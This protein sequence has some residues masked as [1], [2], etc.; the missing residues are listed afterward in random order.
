[1]NGNGGF[2]SRKRHLTGGLWSVND[3]RPASVF[4]PTTEA[5]ADANTFVCEFVG[6]ANANETGVGL[7]LTGA[8][9]VLT[10]VGSVG[11]SSGGYRPIANVNQSFTCTEA[12]LQAFING[13]EWSIL[14]KIKNIG[15]TAVKYPLVLAGTNVLEIQINPATFFGLYHTDASG[16]PHSYLR[17]QTAFV[18]NASYWLAVWKKN[19]VLHFGWVVDSGFP[20]T[21]WDSFPPAQRAAL[22]G[23]A[24]FTADAWGSVANIVG[25]TGYSPVMEIAV[26][27]ASKTG[28]AA[29]PV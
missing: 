22:R 21:G 14:Q 15:T 13:S 19:E 28:L 29:A 23:V 9:L 17:I 18:N 20:P 8:D 2:I 3:A 7:G 11:A 27:V 25:Y 26:V 4:L 16:T 5:A 6:G 10:Q 1:M 24:D 12:M